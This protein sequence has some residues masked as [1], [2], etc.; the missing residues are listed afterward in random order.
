MLEGTHGLRSQGQGVMRKIK[1]Y[2]NRI[3]KLNPLYPRIHVEVWINFDGR[4]PQARM[5][6]KQTDGGRSDSLAQPRNDATK[7]Y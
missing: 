3:D 5:N 6:Q 4:D 7:T 2:H 1:I